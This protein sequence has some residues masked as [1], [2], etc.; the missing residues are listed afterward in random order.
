VSLL[1]GFSYVI[2]GDG[3]TTEKG[4]GRL[5]RDMPFVFVQLN[6]TF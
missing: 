4:I 5:D 6:A 3:L 2:V 1:G